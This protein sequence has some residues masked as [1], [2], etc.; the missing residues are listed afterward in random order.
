MRVERQML[1][2]LS[3]LVAALVLIGLLRDILLPFVAGIILAYFLNPAADW[4]ERR[5][6]PRTWASIV[7][8]ALGAIAL[9]TILV[10]LVPLLLS[11][12]QQFAL[13]LPSELD[14]IRGLVESWA[15]DRLGP[16]F[17]EFEEGLA[18]ASKSAAENW[19]SFAGWVASS[20]WSRSLA[21][22]NFLSLMLITPLVVFYLL[23]DWHPMLGKLDGWLPRE[24][25]P[26]IRRLATEINDAVSAFIRGQG[27]VCV[28]LGMFYAV[29]LTAIGLRYGLLIG[30]ATGAL[31]F[32]PFAGWALGLMTATALAVVQF[33]PETVPILIVVGIFLVGQGLDAAF[34]S[35]QVVGSKIGLHPV[36]LI[37]ALFVFSYLFGFVGMLVAVPVAAAVGVLVR[38]ALHLYLKSSV[39]HGGG[40]RDPA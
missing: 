37:F 13:A 22:F 35:P 40:Q 34:L 12:A 16:R 7:I 9:V 38:H 5:G 2:W 11:Q 36:W 33:W 10:L 15:R 39:Y 29:S 28:I 18:R 32:V 21:L 8:V 30:I 4:L 14:R 25:A 20:I 17:P 1:F 24:H 23:V 6:L 19:A 27:L 31:S 26:A 3:A